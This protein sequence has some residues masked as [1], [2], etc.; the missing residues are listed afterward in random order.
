MGCADPPSKG[1]GAP[2]QCSRVDQKNEVDGGS[3][4]LVHDQMPMLDLA[5]LDLGLPIQFASS[6][7]VSKEI[8]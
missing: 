7:E 6:F 5:S 2:H 3:L 8:H 4:S 1:L